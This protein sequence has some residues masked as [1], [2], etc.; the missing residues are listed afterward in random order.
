M[1]TS[2]PIRK[3]LTIGV[4]LLLVAVTILSFS[5]FRG[6]YAFRG[7]A[8]NV[9]Q[10]ASELPIAIQLAQHVSAMSVT[11]PSR[12]PTD[13]LD[14]HLPVDHWQTIEF[15]NH[16]ES[17][18]Q[19][20]QTYQQVLIENAVVNDNLAQIKQELQI[21]ERMKANLVTIRGLK[22]GMNWPLQDEAG[23]A[24][25]QNAV[26]DLKIQADR[27]PSFLQ[28]QMNDL[29]G[30]VKG[31]YR[32][33]IVLTWFTS[34]SAGALLLVM[35]H[36]F[37]R[38]VFRPLR[39][40]IEGSRHVAAGNFDHRIHLD[41]GDEM[42][43]LAQ[44][45]ND[46][47]LQFQ[48]IRDDLDKQVQQRT[49]EVVRGEQLASVGY[50]AAGVAHE[51]NNPLASIAFC[52]DSLMDR[53]QDVF[54]SDQVLS[55]SED[56]AS[57]ELAIIQEYLKMIQ[58][59]AF[60]CKEITERLLDFSRLGDVE[61]QNVDLRELVQGVIDMV[62]HVGTYK[63]KE[64]VFH[65]PQAVITAVNP[66][67][68]KQV[69]LNLITNGL[70]SLAAGGVVSISLLRR[71]NEVRLVVTDDGCGMT[72]AVKKH[73]FEPFFTSGKEG[74]G[75]G[76]GMSITCRI[77]NE[78]G[79]QIDVHSDGPGRGSRLT[80]KLPLNEAATKEKHHRHQ[81]A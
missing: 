81:A 74:Y 46:M 57:S 41:S 21:V 10:R 3:K 48:Q 50:L 76:L 27:L 9:S 26:V 31:Q 80:V 35:A 62:R 60:R 32:T 1:L 40:L 51:I 25:L 30:D 42:D 2:W 72:E 43:E 73:L 22:V 65:A 64:I 33:W 4:G 66:Q 54:Q 71:D 59:E 78:H 75:T 68:M 49:R 55:D 6:V 39:I 69:T 15:D 70:D 34:I 5:G 16:L 23:M 29:Q 79:G 53:L 13:K 58:Q 61:R 56:S 38:W 63:E 52:S 19:T 18:S 14:G 20:L 7:L 12:L 47:T 11:D 24:Q 45:M 8:R 44:A 36:L 37:Y 17:V 28:G 77:V 67:E